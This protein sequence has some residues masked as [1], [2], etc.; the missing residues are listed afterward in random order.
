MHRDAEL[1]ELTGFGLGATLFLVQACVLGFGWDGRM[2]EFLGPRRRRN[3]H[4]AGRAS[5]RESGQ[6][7]DG[8]SLLGGHGG[9][10]KR[11]AVNL[12]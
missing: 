8:E 1:N 4:Q 10:S 12:T 2:S 7:D 9:F 5:Q 3:R 6:K 11:R